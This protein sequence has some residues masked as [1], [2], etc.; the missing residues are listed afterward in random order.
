MKL[1]L[2]TNGY[3]GFKR[4]VQEVVEVIRKSRQLYMSAVVVG[5]LMSGF[6]SGTRNE[7]NLK[8]LLEF[9]A[10]PYVEFLPVNMT[11]ADRF[12]RISVDLRAAGTPIPTNDIWIAAHAIETGADLLSTDQHFAKVRG[13]VWIDPIPRS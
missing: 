6:R 5:E 2:D 7:E 8:E 3:S 13:L 10:S 9:L 4:G 11:T 12:G 1:A